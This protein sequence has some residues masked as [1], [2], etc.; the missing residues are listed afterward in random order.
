MVFFALSISFLVYLI[1]N[2]RHPLFPAITI[3]NLT[4]LSIMLGIIALAL[5]NLVVMIL[6]RMSHAVEVYIETTPEPDK[7]PEPVKKR[8]SIIH[9]LYDK[10]R[11]VEAEQQLQVA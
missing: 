10:M 1:F 8:G 2:G 7:V 9:G 11:S 3:S 6:I 4:L 5:L